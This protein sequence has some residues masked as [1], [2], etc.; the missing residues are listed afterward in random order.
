M[1]VR[2][3]TSRD[4]AALA[5]MGQRVR[6]RDGYPIYLP[7]GD[8]VAFLGR[9]DPIAAWVAEESTR[10]VGHVAL[11]PSTSDVVTEA[12]RAAGIAG[13]LGV[14]S[15]LLVDPERRRT[16]LGRHLLDVARRHAEEL[17][18]VPVLDVIATSIGPIALYR[19]AGW[20]ELGRVAYRFPDGQHVDELVFCAR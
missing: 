13:P 1:R 20:I 15:R 14:V 4:I 8:Y 12:I 10:L 18:L 6:A 16:G 9:P 17:D 2:A 5:A 3:R 7:G 11:H 19:D